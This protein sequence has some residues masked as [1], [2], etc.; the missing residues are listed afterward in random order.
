MKIDTWGDR[1]GAQVIL[2]ACIYYQEVRSGLLLIV[3]LVMGKG[4]VKFKFLST[5]SIFSKSQQKLQI[6]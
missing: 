2:S 3:N 4:I 6:G 1:R 5:L